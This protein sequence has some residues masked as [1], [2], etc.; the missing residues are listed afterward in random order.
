VDS[1]GNVR[2]PQ[3]GGVAKKKKRAPAKKK[4]SNAKANAKANAKSK[5]DTN[6]KKA[7]AIQKR[8]LTIGGKKSRGENTPAS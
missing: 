5:D 2:E 6:L 4:S 8:P 7:R 3:Q 1:K